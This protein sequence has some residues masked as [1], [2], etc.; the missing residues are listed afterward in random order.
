VIK[1]ALGIDSVYSAN[2]SWFNG[3]AQIDLIID[4]DD[5]VLNLCEMKFYNAPFTIDK[6]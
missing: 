1:T 5:H 4:R 3:K 2:R 6:K